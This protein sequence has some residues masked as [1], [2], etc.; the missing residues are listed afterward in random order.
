MT[1]HYKFLALAVAALL[2]CG[3]ASVNAQNRTHSFT[4]SAPRAAVP[5]SSGTWGH[6]NG[7]WNRYH[8]H[9]HGSNVYFG[10]GFGYPFGFGY[11]YY[12]SYPYDYYPYGAGYGYYNQPVVRGEYAGGYAGNYGSVVVQVQRRLARAGYYRGSIDGVIGSG[13]RRAIRAYERAHGLPVD[14]EI[15]NQLLATMGLA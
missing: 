2:C 11:P 4:P 1:K 9:H 15:D 7:D 5:H 8:H 12:G 13:T 14:G 6:N 3:V 10:V